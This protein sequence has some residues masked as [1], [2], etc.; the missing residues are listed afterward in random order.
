M[1]EDATS[2]GATSAK[3]KFLCSHGG[4][5]L[6]RPSDGQLK[7]VGGE[8]RVICVPRINTFSDLIE[9]ISSMFEGDFVLKYQISSEELDALVSV[10]T[11]E[12]LHHML[13]EYDRLE[14]GGVS[15]LRAFLF[16]AKPTQPEL[17]SPIYPAFESLEQRYVDAVNGVV[18]PINV[19][20]SSSNRLK[21][22]SASASEC[23]SPRSPSPHSQYSS[24]NPD[25]A[26]ISHGGLTRINRVHSSPSLISLASQN[27]QPS[28]NVQN[29]RPYYY[30]T[31]HHQHHHQQQYQLG[32]HPFG[33]HQENHV[34]RDGFGRVVSMSNLAKASHQSSAV[35]SGQ[36]CKGY[37]GYGGHNRPWAH[38]GK[39][40]AA[41]G[42]GSVRT[43]NVSPSRR[44]VIW[45]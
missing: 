14:R 11:D 1:A 16:P 44:G 13:D 33:K 5:I 36:L 41:Y 7:Y 40:P 25:N 34:P 26:P 9:K 28:S 20:P 24:I 2:S 37:T 15:K 17:Y 31:H 18:R 23:T 35:Y 30:Q 12:D 42:D 3:V 21:S 4:K 6:P 39:P 29:H 10:K 45:E 32:H 43:A 19:R 22:M 8:T 27:P 38:L